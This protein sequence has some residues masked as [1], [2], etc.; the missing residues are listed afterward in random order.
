SNDTLKKVISNLQTIKQQE[1]DKQNIELGQMNLPAERLK[2]SS[3]YLESEIGF[4]RQQANLNKESWKAIDIDK[5]MASMD[6]S[7]ESLL[8]PK[9]EAKKHIKYMKELY[10]ENIIQKT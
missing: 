7:K 6:K 9:D 10:L 5:E 8:F 4:L 1:L 3:Q 2:L